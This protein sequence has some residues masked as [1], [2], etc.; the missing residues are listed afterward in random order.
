M[1]YVNSDDPSIFVEKRF[2]IGY[3]LNFAHPVSWL[4]LGLGILAPLAVAVWVTHS[5]S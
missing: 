3:T 4:I 2:G 1:F 5:A